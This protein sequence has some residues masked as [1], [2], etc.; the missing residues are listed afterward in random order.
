MTDSVDVRGR[1]GGCGDRNTCDQRIC[2]MTV[3]KCNSHFS[4]ER[5]HTDEPVNLVRATERQA[6]TIDRRQAER[7]RIKSS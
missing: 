5:L 3:G 1:G 4:L 2:E 6:N 7:R